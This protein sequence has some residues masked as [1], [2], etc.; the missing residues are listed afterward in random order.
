MNTDYAREAILHGLVA[1]VISILVTFGVAQVVPTDDLAWAIYAVG[2]ASFFS[3]FFAAY[4]SLNEYKHA[5]AVDKDEDDG[6]DD[7]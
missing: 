7:A 3:A 6:D 5:D 1:V 4:Y 2:Y